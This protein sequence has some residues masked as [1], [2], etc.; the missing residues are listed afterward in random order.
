MGREW[1]E[2]RRDGQWA[3]WNSGSGDGTVGQMEQWAKMGTVG[4]RRNS[5]PRWNS[6]AQS[7]PPNKK[8]SSW[9][10]FFCRCSVQP[11]ASAQQNTPLRNS[12]DPTYHKIVYS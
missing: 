4:P 9:K 1:N 8:G 6:Q 5:G 11:Q 10:I 2:W 3:E 7:M 12:T